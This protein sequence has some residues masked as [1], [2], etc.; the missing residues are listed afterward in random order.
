MR[1]PEN[2]DPSLSS[3]LLKVQ[4]I[5][6]EAPPNQP[7]PEYRDPEFSVGPIRVYK[8]SAGQEDDFNL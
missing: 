5:E 8:A 4:E 1:V 7:S 2:I 3:P 6:F